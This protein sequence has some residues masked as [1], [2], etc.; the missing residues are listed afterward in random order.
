[1]IVK[2][3]ADFLNE[4]VLPQ[5]LGKES[6]KVED[7]QPII[8]VGSPTTTYQPP[9]E[10]TKIASMKTTDYTAGTETIVNTENANKPFACSS[11][12]TASKTLSECISQD[13]AG[14]KEQYFACI[15]TADGLLED[16]FIINFKFKYI[17]SPYLEISEEIYSGSQICGFGASTARTVGFSYAPDDEFA[18][19]LTFIISYSSTAS[20]NNVEVIAEDWLKTDG[21]YGSAHTVSVLNESA[22]LSAN[23]EHTLII[24]KIDDKIVYTFDDDVIFIETIV[25]STKDKDFFFEKAFWPD[26]SGCIPVL[27]RY[28]QQHHFAGRTYFR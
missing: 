15:K 6:I 16:D 9:V 23:S 25:D 24:T 27:R 12:R 18:S 13:T 8:S 1:M 2:Q 7:L 5:Y 26:A 28:S 20:A 11:I 17:S 3:L 10:P 19:G 21:N 22:T 14:I 4:T